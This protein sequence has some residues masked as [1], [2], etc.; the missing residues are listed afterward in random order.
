MQPS[1]RKIYFYVL[2]LVM[3]ST[4]FSQPL[5]KSSSNNPKTAKAEVK[6]NT[7]TLFEGYFKILSAGV[8]IG[9]NVVK[10]QY[11]PTQKKFVGAY[12]T[13]TNSVG[14]DI[15]E[16]LKAEADQDLK[17]ISYQYTSKVGKEITIIDAKFSKNKMTADIN[18]N[19]KTRKE[20]LDIP[21][22]SFLSVF[23]IY[24]MLKSPSGLQA[25]KKYSYKAIAEEDAKIYS[26]E[27][28]VGKEEKYNGI[29]AF[30]ILNNFKDIKFISYVTDRGEVL[31]TE[32]LAQN[33]KTELVAKPGDATAKFNVSSSNL[34]QVFGEVPLGTQN[35]LSQAL[36]GEV[37]KAQQPVP[38]K[39]QGI[40]PGQGVILKGET[41][42]PED[43]KKDGK[44]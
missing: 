34:K 25:D 42:K 12:F 8:P 7:E 43:A 44:E 13:K 21:K 37:F 22:G 36:E 24:L 28:T 2:S 18:Q 17:P 27:A 1:T 14:N 39:Q 41:T 31:A 9:Y 10:Y 16:S 20:Q 15:T 33:V 38:T 32:S 11:I 30:K 23:L 29:R 5:P 3:A 4:S 35:I 40:P 6:K 26:G 19:G